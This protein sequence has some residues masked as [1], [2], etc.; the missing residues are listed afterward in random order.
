M[1]WWAN[2]VAARVK[3]AAQRAGGALLVGQDLRVGQ[4]GVVID[5]G[6][7]VVEAGR[8]LLVPVID[9]RG[10]AMEAPPAAVGDAAE[11]LDVDVDQLTRRL[12]LIT[13]GSS[14]GGA[15]RQTG[16]R[17]AVAQARYLV[18]GQDPRHRAGRHAGSR[19]DRLRPGAQ[20][21]ASLHDPL[22]DLRG[23]AGRCAVRAA[24]AVGH[25]G[26]TLGPVA[27]CPG[28]GALARDS[29]LAGHVGD[30]TAIINDSTRQDQTTMR[31]QTSISVRH[32]D[33]RA[34]EDGISTAPGGLPMIKQPRRYQRDG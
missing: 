8:D 6:V 16:D 18:A 10:S 13:A 30:P 29:H 4:P 12:A 11:F 7:H 20:L 3:K 26:L 27:L 31:R 2:H 1:P 19:T 28:R 32:E 17:V 15:H 33:L 9:G 5:R 14:T 24:G 34:G 23:G 22:L 21:M 25:P